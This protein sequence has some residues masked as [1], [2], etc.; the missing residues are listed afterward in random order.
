MQVLG[1][2]KVINNAAWLIAGKIIQALIAFAVGTVSARYLGPDNYGL[3]SYGSSVVAFVIPIMN[4]GLP[5]ILVQEVTNY[6]D[7]EGEIFG[8]SILLSIISS[9]VCIVLVTAYTYLV[10]VD[11]TVTNCVVMLYSMMLF[12]Q[13][14]HLIEYWFQAKLMSKYVSFV[15]LIAYVIVAAYKI[16]LLIN[17]ASVYF[18][19]IS[20]ALDYLIISIMLLVAYRKLGGKH[21][22]FSLDTARRLFNSSKYYIVSSLMVTIF[23]QTDKIMI[24]LMINESAVGFY[25]AAIT[26]AGMTSFVFCA[27]I[28]SMRPMI[29]VC[30]KEKDIIGYEKNIARTYCIIIYLALFQCVLM[31][32]FAPF[33]IKTIYGVDYEQAI[34]T[35]QII[36]WY[37]TFS[38]MGSV[39]N[40]WILGEGKQ[41]YLWILNL[42]GAVMNIILNAVFIPSMGINGAALASLITQIFTNVFMNVIVWP[43]RHNNELI[44][45]G[46]NPKLITEFFL[47]KAI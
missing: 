7:K 37:T 10:D 8:S 3:I 15:S 11:E 22:R 35:L 17:G 9:I 27:V 6:P 5:N 18:F 29:F 1:N 31:S 34:T 20:N 45:K 30:K 23:A 46:I 19:A 12:F 24:K 40:I 28:D 33:I 2:N 25:S 44:F 47:K 21:L 4:L 36:V 32:Y 14:F 43:L 42:G 39:R 26:C 16:I 38:Y 13:A 41:K